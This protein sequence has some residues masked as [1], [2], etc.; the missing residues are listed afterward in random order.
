SM[1]RD[2]IASEV[3]GAFYLIQQNLYNTIV[4]MGS[5]DGG[6]TKLLAT[7]VPHKGVIAIDS[8]PRMTAHGQHF[9][10]VSTV[11]YITQDM[12]VSWPELSDNI[13]RLESKVD[14]IFSNFSFH[15]FH[16]KYQLL[17]ICRQLLVT[18]GT[19]RANI[20][21][22]DDL[23]DKLPA[24]QRLEWCPSVDQQLD[25][26]RRELS[27]TGFTINEFETRKVTFA[28]NRRQI[29]AY[30]PVLMSVYKSYFTASGL[31][32][33]QCP[34]LAD[35]VFNV[36]NNLGADRPNP[37]AWTLFLAKEDISEVVTHMRLLRLVCHKN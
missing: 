27:D 33:N 11:E 32:Y 36:Y 1:N 7:R 18:G 12:S 9:N 21:L 5:G 22:F 13:R 14:L 30:L 25:V 29:I 15:Y 2:T 3:Y 34:D 37:N 17:S 6:I 24:N 28:V 26:W 19:I 8:N 23:S 4:D 10:S 20:P 31:P 35:I 16:D